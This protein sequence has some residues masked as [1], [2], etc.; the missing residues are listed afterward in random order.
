MRPRHLI[1]VALAALALGSAIA[2]AVPVTVPRITVNDGR[3]VRAEGVITSPASAD[4][5]TAL[6]RAQIQVPEGGGWRVV[7]GLGNHRI[8][9]CPG[10]QNRG[11]TYSSFYVRFWGMQYLRSQPARLCWSAT[12]TIDGTPSRH[13]SCKRFYLRGGS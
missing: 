1:P 4:T 13:V 11:V 10:S 6:V 7:R 3:V 12:Q 9:V 2:Q 8:D 5:C